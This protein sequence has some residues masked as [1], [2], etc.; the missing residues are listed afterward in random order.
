[1]HALGQHLTGDFFGCASRLLD[2]AAHLESEL[3][4]VARDVGATVI[5]A[6]FH[7][8]APHGVSGVVVIQESHL[9]IHTW[10][11][12]GYA[13]V[14]LFT[15]GDQIDPLAALPA[16][17]EVLGAAEVR[18]E[19]QPRG[20]WEDLPPMPDFDA[21]SHSPAPPV[22]YSRDLWFTAR[23]ETLALSLKLRGSRLFWH[24]SPQQRIEVY[25]SLAYGRFMALDGRIVI[26]EHDERSYHE[27]LVHLPMHLLP[28]ARRALVL[29]GGDG[30]AVRELLRYPQLS[31]VEVVEWDAA[32]SETVQ[33]YLPELGRGLHDPKVQ[34]YHEEALDWLTAQTKGRQDLILVDLVGSLSLWPEDQQWAFLHH[35]TQALAP[36]GM[37]MMAGPDPRHEAQAF[38]HTWRQLNRAFPY[39][40]V[41]TALVTM[42]TYPSGQISL[43]LA[44]AQS[45]NLTEPRVDHSLQE[46][47]VYHPEMHRAAFVLPNDL[48][49]RLAKG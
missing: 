26:S 38:L 33:R 1:M 3:I 28:Q 29:G 37:L 41:A 14:D 23:S 43:L 11:E 12:G 18:H 47:Q 13:A 45:G 25:D 10:P 21:T 27:M 19:L 44:S 40:S 20:R 31:K 7:H 6:T 17:Q 5:N 2:D 48:R 34:V 24:D 39:G 46:L 49:K 22:H 32:V 9:A 16:L 15:C 35:L 42:P 8:F 4:R 30:G 36:G